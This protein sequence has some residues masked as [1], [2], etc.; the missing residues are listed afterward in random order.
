MLWSL[1]GPV[2]RKKIIAFDGLIIIIGPSGWH[3]HNLTIFFMFVGG[4]RGNN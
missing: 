4:I 1:E 2:R 3:L